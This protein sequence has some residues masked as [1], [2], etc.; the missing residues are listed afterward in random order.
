MDGFDWSLTQEAEGNIRY[1]NRY[2]RMMPGGKFLGKSS[3]NSD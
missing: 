1:I 2:A 3:C